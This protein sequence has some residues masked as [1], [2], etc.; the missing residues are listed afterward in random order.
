[1]TDLHEALDRACA[2]VGISVPKETREGA[3]VR[4]DTFSGRNG[5]GDGSV[6][7]NGDIVFAM[8][9]QTGQRAAVRIG[10]PSQPVDRKAIAQRVANDRRRAREKAEDAAAVARLLVDHAK[11]GTHPYLALKGFPKEKTLIVPAQAVARIGGKYLMV[12]GADRAILLPARIGRDVVSAQIIWPDG[13]KK[14]LY[15]GQMDGATYRLSVGAETWVCEGFATGLSLLAALRGMNRRDGVVCGFSAYG[16]Y[17]AART[18]QGRVWLAVDHDKPLPQ[19]DGLG[20][21]E[22]WARQANRSYA[23]PPHLGDDINDL[24]VGHGIYA[25]QRLLRDTIRKAAV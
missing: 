24:H 1:M 10:D 16:V 20:T 11:M 5:K 2:D 17:A 6:K 3:W 18:M 7:V 4:T 25:V 19:F 21:G 9:F 8:N 13:T 15:G 23:M 14:F 12:E 22:H